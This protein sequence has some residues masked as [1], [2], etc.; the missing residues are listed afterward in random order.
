MIITA[1][2][3]E[4]LPNHPKV[5]E[6]IRLHY[7]HLYSR[8][9]LVKLKQ[10][11]RPESKRFEGKLNERSS[12]YETRKRTRPWDNCWFS[13]KPHIINLTVEEA[14]SRY[15]DYILWC[16]DNLS[17]KWSTHTVRLIESKVKRPMYNTTIVTMG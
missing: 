9:K 5:E 6:M 15:P 4:Q 12:T 14:V 17:I 1:E 11:H 2:H 3:L 7:P 16:Y 10:S 13:N 8:Y